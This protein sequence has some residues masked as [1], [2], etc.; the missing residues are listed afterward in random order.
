[1]KLDE[2]NKNQLLWITKKL[3]KEQMGGVDIIKKQ[4]NYIYKQKVHYL[5]KYIVLIYR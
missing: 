4:S 3:L 1:M 5:G 2:L